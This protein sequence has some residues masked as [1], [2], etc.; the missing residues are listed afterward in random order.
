MKRKSKEEKYKIVILNIFLNVLNLIF[1][2]TRV[3]FSYE[4]FHC[5]KLLFSIAV[6]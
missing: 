3:G 2:R 5:S 4:I 6:H 1:K